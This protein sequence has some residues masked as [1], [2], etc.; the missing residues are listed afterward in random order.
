MQ[1]G[2]DCLGPDGPLAVKAGLLETNL[3]IWD[4]SREQGAQRAGSQ[5]RPCGSGSTGKR[6]RPRRLDP[7]WEQDGYLG[8]EGGTQKQ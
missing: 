5:G 8:G 7:W 3:S 1:L 4:S 2:Q 6:P